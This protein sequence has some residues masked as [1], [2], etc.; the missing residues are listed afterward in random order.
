MSQDNI[1]FL[2]NYLQNGYV[3]EYFQWN[4]HLNNI[5]NRLSFLENEFLK[6]Q[7]KNNE[8]LK[9]LNNFLGEA[10]SQSKIINEKLDQNSVRMDEMLQSS[11][12]CEKMVK[13]NNS[14][15]LSNIQNVKRIEKKIN[16]NNYRNNKNQQ[17]NNS[18]KNNNIQNNSISDDNFDSVDMV[19]QIDNF[20]RDDLGQM[21]AMD[22]LSPIMSLINGPKKIKKT[23]DNEN[24]SENESNSEMD[25]KEKDDSESNLELYSSINKIEDIIHVGQTL[26]TSKKNLEKTPMEEKI[27][28]LVKPLNKLK[29]MIGLKSLKQSIYDMVIYYLQNFEKNNN[30]LHTVIEGS[31]GV[32]KTEVGKILA[33]IYAA[34][35]IIPSSRFKM[36][37]RTD[38]IGE[39]LGHTAMKTQKIIDEADGGVLFIDE[40]Y[41][42]GNEEKKDSFSKECL[43][44]LNQNLS[45]NKK[46]LIC[47]VAG[48]PD[49]LEKCFFS[50]NP[51]LSRRFP[52]RFKIDGYSHEEL[53]DIFIKKIKDNRWFLDNEIT[54]DYL[55]TFFKENLKEFKNFGGDIDNL[56]LNCKFSHSNRIFGKKTNSK[57][58]LNI[59]DI[60]NGFRKYQNNKRKEQE[61]NFYNFY[62]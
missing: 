27:I 22:L 25:D 31:P 19:I 37:K 60:I 41:G 44:I 15:L 36:V 8:Q 49:E 28:K 4:Y 61:D 5:Y 35:G 50:Y 32:G 30:M 18:K 24:E 12:L 54:D 1:N 11:V 46:K 16:N 56:L 51:G 40:A 6:L 21:N 52:F 3:T 26:E 55:N 13:K 17:P 58:K 48:Y 39:Y 23:E 43:D 10:T 2:Q 20:P 45:E 9:I 34:L 62:L 59:M 7:E 38:L 57:K 53:K 47:I 42:L 29:R 33:Q 14:L